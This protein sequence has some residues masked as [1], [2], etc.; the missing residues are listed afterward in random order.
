MI[1]LELCCRTLLVVVFAVAAYGKATAFADFTGSLRGLPMLPDVLLPALAVAVLAGE[2]AIV[3]LLALPHGGTVGATVAG[4]T[5]F[6]FGALAVFSARRKL[7][8]R[9]RCFG[10]NAGELGTSQAVRNAVLVAIAVAA[11]YA[12]RT[13]GHGVATADVAAASFGV[14]LG[15][16]I[17][18]W[19]DLAF[20]FTPLP[21]K[22]R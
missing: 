1:Y 20:L 8:I 6:A 7:G 15:C 19:D 3:V 17:V 12:A 14:V 16:L 18:R 21:I 2:T 4:L 9:C 11:G 13:A 5:L 10:T 22:D